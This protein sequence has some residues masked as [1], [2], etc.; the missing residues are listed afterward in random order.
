MLVTHSVHKDKTRIKANRKLATQL[1]AIALFLTG[2]IVA[3]ASALA[4]PQVRAFAGRYVTVDSKTG[5]Q[6]YYEESGSGDPVLFVPGWTMTVPFFRHQLDYFQGS[7]TTRFITY[8]PRAHGRSTKTMEGAN[9]NQHARDLKVMIDRLH[10]KNVVLGGWSWGMDTVYAYISMYGTANIRAVVNMDQTPNPL[11]SGDG[12]W[13][14]GDFT[15]VKFFFD[16]FTEDRAG[17]TRQFMPSF[18]DKSVPADELQWMTSEAMMTPNVVAGL[19][20]YDGWYYNSTEIVR[21]L[22]IPQIYFVDKQNTPAAKSYLAQNAP[23]AELISL[24]EHASFYDQA[25]IFNENLARFLAK[26]P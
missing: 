11:A 7:K 18:F 15:S 23:N 16:K 19:L 2:L 6:L 9:Y 25:P 1:A 3:P 26:H 14:D 12:A 5:V 24:G 10:L 8:D 13:S 22:K 4:E 17:T 21:N 20:Y